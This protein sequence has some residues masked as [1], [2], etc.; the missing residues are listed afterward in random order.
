MRKIRH[1]KIKNTGILFELLSAQITADIINNRQSPAIDIVKKYFKKGTSLHKE[2]LLYQVLLKEKYNS[3]TKATMLLEEVIKNSNSINKDDLRK[4]KYNLIKEIKNSYDLDN[5]YKNQINNYKIYASIY[6]ILENTDLLFSPSEI[7]TS[8]ITLLEFI[9]SK[10][11][12]N[13]TDRSRIVEE[14]S[15]QDADIRK[16]S[17]KIL[18]DRFNT[19]YK[20]FNLQ[21]KTLLREY[22]NNISDS[23]K[24]KLYINSELEKIVTSITK[25]SKKVTDSA[26]K[27]KLHEVLNII[28]EIVSKKKFNESTLLTVLHIYKLDDEIK[29]IVK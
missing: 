3:E 16:L 15:K 9:T 14:Y 10:T 22:I 19:K 17:Y 28:N 13:K 21:Q 8:K 27:I 23:P 29:K 1:N 24:M 4:T 20:D 2:L 18:V 7:V 11:P 6:N 26:T 5:F 25:N 12:A